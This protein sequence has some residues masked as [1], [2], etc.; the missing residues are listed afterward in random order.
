N[1][2]GTERI[3][4]KVPLDARDGNIVVE[5][6]SGTS[7]AQLFRVIPRIVSFRPSEGTIGSEVTIYG[8]GF[9]DR[10]LQVLFGNQ[11]V[12]PVSV[13]PNPGGEDTVVFRVPSGSPD[14]SRIGVVLGPGR[15]AKSPFEFR[16]SRFEEFQGLLGVREA[17]YEDR[18]ISEI[19]RIDCNKGDFV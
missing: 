3:E 17:S 15:E 11:T 1:D 14:R 12:T 13:V 6:P 10:N 2:G 5:T 9:F 19:L 4:V 18:T 7:T 8:K 16:I